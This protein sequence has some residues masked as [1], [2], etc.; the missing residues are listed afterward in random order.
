MQTAFFKHGC[1]LWQLMDAHKIQRPRL[2]ISHSSAMDL[3]ESV[4]ASR[5]CMQKKKP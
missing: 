1:I 5:S 3:I 2:V 4:S